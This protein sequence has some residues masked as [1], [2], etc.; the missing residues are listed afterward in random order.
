MITYD[1]LGATYTGTRRPDPRVGAQIRVAL[2]PSPV[3]IG[4]RPAGSAAA[5]QARAEALP[6]P[7]AAADAVLAA[8]LGRLEADLASGRWHERHAELLNLESFDGG[9]RL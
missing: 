5:V 1:T 6:V 4:Q 2:E 3:T 9:Y 8:G 7:D